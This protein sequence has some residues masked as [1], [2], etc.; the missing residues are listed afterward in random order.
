MHLWFTAVLLMAGCST[1][2]ATHEG[3]SAMPEGF[4]VLDFGAVGDGITDNTAAFQSALDAAAES[5]NGVVNA[6]SGRY[7]FDGRLVFPAAVSLV[8]DWQSVPSH[9]GWDGVSVPVKNTVLLPVGDRGQADAGAFIQLN[10]NCTLRGVSIFYPEQNRDGEPAVYPYAISMRGNNPAVLDV[11]LVNPYQGIDARS[12][13]RALIRNVHGQPL[14]MGIYVDQVYDIGRIENVHWNPYWSQDGELLRWMLDH[15]EAF[16]F[17]RTDWHYVLNTFCFGYRYGYRF[18]R[19]EDGYCNGNFLGIGAD[20]CLV[21]VQ[22]DEASETGLLITNGEFVSFDDPDP[23]MVVV[24]DENHG[25]I[26][27]VNC[28]YWGP[29]NQIARI[30]GDGAVC[31]S[32]CIFRE[33]DRKGEGRYAIQASG[34]DLMVRG[35]TFEKN[36]PQIDLSPG[37]RRAIVTDNFVNGTVRIRIAEGVRARVEGN[38]GD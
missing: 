22:V 38:I 24:G 31:F 2:S 37:V 8:G 23:T 16:V 4:N 5:A 14:R 7:R 34:G 25:R 1:M 36:A 35:C 27:F 20:R 21:A 29:N 3:T 19:T 11:E 17:G 6:P 26:Q 10:A 12:N 33:H 28:A 9:E 32:E 15:G 30:G 18:I 13:Q